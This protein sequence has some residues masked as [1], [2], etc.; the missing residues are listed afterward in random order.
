MG[1]RNRQDPVPVLKGFEEVSNLSYGQTDLG[2]LIQ[3]P[4]QLPMLF[5]PSIGVSSLLLAFF[6]P[7]HPTQQVIIFNY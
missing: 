6:T 4:L 1:L 5:L 3:A 2:Y 7:F